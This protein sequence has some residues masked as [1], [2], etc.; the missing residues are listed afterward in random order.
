M[1]ISLVNESSSSTMKLIS[2]KLTTESVSEELIDTSVVSSTT[3]GMISMLFSKDSNASIILE[4][5]VSTSA[6]TDKRLTT[7]DNAKRFFKFSAF[8]LTLIVL[9]GIIS[10]VITAVAVYFV[11]KLIQSSST[12]QHSSNAPMHE[13]FSYNL[14]KQND[15]N[16]N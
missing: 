12:S 9:A 14:E 2:M 4:L 3:T 5:F 8:T 1:F 15:A 10:C 11:G 13:N 16:N 6:V 7:K